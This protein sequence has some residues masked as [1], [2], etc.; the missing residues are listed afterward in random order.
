MDSKKEKIRKQTW[1]Y[2]WQQ[3]IIEIVL[4]AI[5]IPSIIFLPYL[6]GS[7]LGDNKSSLCGASWEAES[8]G[9]F[10]TW[11][12][13]ISWILIST[14]V[15]FLVGLLIYLWIEKNWEIAKDRARKKMR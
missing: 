5:I 12:E 9:I 13:G 8:C 7:N 1:K 3:K 14:L 15:L 6:L 11:V 2:F 10:A 4:A